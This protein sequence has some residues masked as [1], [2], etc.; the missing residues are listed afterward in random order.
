MKQ[1]N[2]TPKRTQAER[3]RGCCAKNVDNM[4]MIIA[5]SKLTERIHSIEYEPIV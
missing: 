1:K 3:V 4:P 2:V 5:I